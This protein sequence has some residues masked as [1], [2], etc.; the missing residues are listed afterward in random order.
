MIN[1]Y[2]LNINHAFNFVSLHIFTQPRGSEYTA[3]KFLI[4]AD[5]LKIELLL[6]GYITIHSTPIAGTCIGRNYFTV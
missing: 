3:W 6:C 5:R 1:I 2:F 4:N